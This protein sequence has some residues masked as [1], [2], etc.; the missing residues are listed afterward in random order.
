[1][2][3]AFSNV[4]RRGRAILTVEQAQV[5]Y[6]HKSITFDQGKDKAGVLARMYGVNIKTVRDVW[7]GRTWY[8]ATFHMDHTQ[9]FSPERLAR[10][11]GRPKGAK[12]N[13]PRSRKAQVDQ[14]CIETSDPCLHV[15]ILQRTPFMPSAAPKAAVLDW[16]CKDHQTWM[17]VPTVFP[18]GRFEDPFREDWE[19]ALQTMQSNKHNIKSDS[20]NDRSVEQASKSID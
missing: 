10:K 17:D 14:A 3:L 19:D 18:S 16:E 11:A 15:G 4:K 2:Q 9:P 7:I 20:C 6:R 13:K 5:I 1:M 12:D 8:R